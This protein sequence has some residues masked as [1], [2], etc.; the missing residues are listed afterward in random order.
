MNK[1]IITLIIVVV[2]ILGTA[3]GLYVYNT[4]NSEVNSEEKVLNQPNE[5]DEYTWSENILTYKGENSKTALELL[6]KYAKTEKNG[7]GEMAYITSINGITPGENQFWSFYIN[8]KSS[9]LG[10]G[11]YIT[12]DS[13]TIVWKLDSF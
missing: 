10:A 12:S 6:E 11:S 5:D 2:V 1:K 3:T 9:E 4:N 13:D 8:D 7:E